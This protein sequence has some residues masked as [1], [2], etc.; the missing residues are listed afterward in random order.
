[1]II[2]WDGSIATLLCVVGISLLLAT[3][4]IAITERNRGGK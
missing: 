1:M 4:T 2:F 3:A